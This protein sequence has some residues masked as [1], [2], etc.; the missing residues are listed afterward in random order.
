MTAKAYQ[1]YVDGKWVGAASG[2]TYELPN[3]ATEQIVGV[4]PDADREDMQ[5]AIA[6][7]RRAFDEGPWRSTTPRER[8]R[9]LEALAEALERRKEE[10]R[11]LLVR[12]HAAEG[13]THAIQLEEPIQSLRNYADIL[14]RFRF[15]EPLDSLSTIGPVGPTVVNS[16]LH[17]QPVGVCGLIPTWNFPLYVTVQKI[18][19]AIAAGCTMVIKPSPFGPLIDCLIAELVDE[20]GLP[21]GVFNL[22]TGQSDELGRELTEN[23]AVDKISFTGAVST[24]KKVMEAASQSLK[25]VHLELGGKS[26]MIVLDD[27]EIAAASPA[28]ASPTF[29]HA[30]QGCAITTRVLVPRKLHDPLVDRMKSFI[31]AFVKVGDPAEPTTILGPVIREQRRVAIEEYIASGVSEGADLVMGG[32]RPAHLEK[33]YFLEPTV[34]ANVRNEM[35]IAREEIFGPVVSVIPYEDEDDAVRIANDSSLGLYGGILTTNTN[36][37]LSVAKKLRTG[38]VGINGSVNLR[39][40]PF[41]GFKESGIGREGGVFGL[42][43][44]LELQAITWPA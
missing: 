7:A 20:V 8:V 12:A 21:P 17:H 16:L 2:A 23:P 39:A 18:A 42:R 44:F 19:P 25:R 24:G 26:A 35:R 28:A 41:G 33:G 1:M 5:R 6:A 29:F 32:G 36:R 30:G 27:A 10:F 43:E 15:E 11:D 22:V 13:L 9:I 14:L 37:A 3:P 4:V 34:F 40:C 38:G 31:E